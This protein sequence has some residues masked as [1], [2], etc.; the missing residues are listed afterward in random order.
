MRNQDGESSK[1]LNHA[2]NTLRGSFCATLRES[3]RQA[4]A[5]TPAAPAAPPGRVPPIRPQIAPGV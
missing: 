2:E 5:A 3:R 4:P 1:T